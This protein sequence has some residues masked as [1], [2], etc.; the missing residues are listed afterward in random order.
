MDQDERRRDW[1]GPVLQVG[2]LSDAFLA[3]IR[4]DNPEAE[5]VD[6][7]SYVRVLVPG[8]C[9]LTRLALEKELEAEVRFPSDLEAV[10]ASFKGRLTLSADEARW[11]FTSTERE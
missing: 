6:R 4:A 7:G 8:R 3:A 2:P 10:M 11:E 5:F 9:R 1:V